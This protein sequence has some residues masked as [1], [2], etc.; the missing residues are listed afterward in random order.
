MASTPKKA[1]RRGGA[2]PKKAMQSC[3]QCGAPN[4]KYMVATGDTT[5]GGPYCARCAR[6]HGAKV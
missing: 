4:A 6:L 2:R 3:V 1:E 5:M